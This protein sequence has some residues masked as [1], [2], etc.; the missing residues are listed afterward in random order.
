MADGDGGA[1][2][3]DATAGSVSPLSDSP[4]SDSATPGRA[5][6]TAPAFRG[7]AWSVR[8]DTVDLG[9]AGTVQRDVVEH[10][11][12]V[13]ILAL[14]EKDRMVVVRQYRHPVASTLWE[15]PA[16]MLD[17]AGEPWDRCAARELAEEAGVQ[18]RH[19]ATLIDLYPT[20]GGS[21]ERMRVFLA[22]GLSAAPMPPGFVADGEEADLVVERHPLADVVDAVLAG[23]LRNAALV[24]AVLALVVHRTTGRDLRA[25]DAPWWAQLDAP[26]SY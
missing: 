25:A 17:V 20:A 9:A 15:L 8:T 16:G 1:R 5:I 3:G 22:T 24:A 12:A 19:W 7:G 21:S 6:A 14:D 23:R 13:A 2:P 10:P 26:A 18:A 11:G 4:L